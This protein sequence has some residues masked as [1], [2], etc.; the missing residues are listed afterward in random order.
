MRLRDLWELDYILFDYNCHNSFRFVFFFLILNCQWGL[1]S[2]WPS[3]QKKQK[4]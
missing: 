4:K 1:N 2:N 3:Y